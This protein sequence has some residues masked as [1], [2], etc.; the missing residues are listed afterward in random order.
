MF[1][2]PS[3]V[4]ESIKEKC[5]PWTSSI[6]DA[7]DGSLS[8]HVGQHIVNSTN[9]SDVCSNTLDKHAAIFA[10]NAQ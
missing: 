4:A 9:L 7:H 1:Q 8:I 5:H 2:R 6:S 3:N 10:V